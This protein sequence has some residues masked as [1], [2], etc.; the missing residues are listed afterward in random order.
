M[1][2]YVREPRRPGE[3]EADFEARDEAH[4]QRLEK[5]AAKLREL[6][7]AHASRTPKPKQRTV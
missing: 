1:S 7:E 6:R 5:D 3:S 4:W 2:V